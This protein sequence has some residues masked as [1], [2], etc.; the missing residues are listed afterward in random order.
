[1]SVGSP[2]GADIMARSHDL[3]ILEWRDWLVSFV[4]IQISS[5]SDCSSSS[6]IEDDGPPII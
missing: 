6:A 4:S 1:M 2:S 3:D 5:Q